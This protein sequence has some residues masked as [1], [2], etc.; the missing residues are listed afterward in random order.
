MTTDG[1]TRQMIVQSKAVDNS[2][3]AY[4]LLTN[5]TT[6][7]LSVGP[8]PP[9]SV[10]ECTT[11]PLPKNLDELWRERGNSNLACRGAEV[12]ILTNQRNDRGGYRYVGLI[13]SR[14][15]DE[16]ECWNRDGEPESGNPDHKLGTFPVERFGY[17]AIC[18]GCVTSKVCESESAA[19][20]ELKLQ[21][22]LD[23]DAELNPEDVFLVQIGCWVSDDETERVI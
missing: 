11:L 10:P 4:I 9:I 14:G 3:R 15:D 2:H 20:Q 13:H 5:K 1:I 7:E 23:R 21:M 19:I 6:E 17:I 12:T 16:V 22:G 18:K 8:E